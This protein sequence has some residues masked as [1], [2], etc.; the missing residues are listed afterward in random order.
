MVQCEGQTVVLDEDLGLRHKTS[1][2]VQ[3][4]KQPLIGVLGREKAL[5]DHKNSLHL[6]T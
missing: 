1:R 2:E 4:R 5:M 3:T 6:G